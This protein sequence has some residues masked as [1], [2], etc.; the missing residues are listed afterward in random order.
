[1]DMCTMKWILIHIQ[2]KRAQGSLELALETTTR[3]IHIFQLFWH[4]WFSHR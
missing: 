2:I 4:T 1:M 3:K